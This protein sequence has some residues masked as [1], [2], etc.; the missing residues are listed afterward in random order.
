MRRALR[1]LRAVIGATFVAIA[2]S[3]DPSGDIEIPE[4]T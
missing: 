2:V 4:A 1:I 3:M